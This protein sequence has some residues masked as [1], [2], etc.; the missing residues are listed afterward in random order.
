MIME[1]NVYTRLRG[2]LDTLP[3]GFP[4]TPTGVEI[5]ILKRLFTP[6]QAEL[7]MKLKQDPEEV[8]SIAKRIKMDESEL[9]PKL[10]E[11]ALKGLIF[12]TKDQGKM[13]YQAFQFVIGIYEFQVKNLDKE[14]CE[15]FEEYLPY[16]G[17]SL[18]GVKTK[19]LRVV[20]VESAL[21]RKSIVATYN[22]I[23]D[24]VREQDN[25]VVTECICAKEQG[26][27]GN[28]C[29]KP[30]ETCIA[31]GDFAQYYIDNNMGRKISTDETFKLL[32]RAEDLGLVLQPTN[33][34]EIAAVCC[35]CSCCC[36]YL[37]F[38]KMS[39][40][41]AEFFTSYYRSTID[42]DLCTACG[43]CIDRCPMDAI[44]L[45]E[46]VTEVKEKNCIGCGLCVSICPEEA[47]SLMEKPSM[48]IPQM[49]IMDTFNKI[50]TERM[51]LSTAK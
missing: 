23:R 48:E 43:E 30:I 44:E 4:E 18:A 5:K 17:M 25:I 46:A 39:D 8:S 42:S 10:E 14:F 15:L 26:I 11:M 28:D 51:V 1:D 36:P 6:E 34:Q 24:L 29:Y 50:K 41:P 40:R 9:A 7:T 19:Q 31:F 47:I 21:S 37:R 3:T 12:R 49:T 38:A 16:F 45:V 2:F 33:T 35:C 27:L 22:N 32:D 13:L 20:P